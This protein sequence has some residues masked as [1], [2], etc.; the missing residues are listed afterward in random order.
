M[1]KNT[2]PAAL[3]EAVTDDHDCVR[4]LSILS[5]KIA[6]LAPDHADIPCQAQMLA[7]GLRQCAVHPGAVS[8][9][10]DRGFDGHTAVGIDRIPARPR[11]VWL[12]PRSGANVAARVPR[13]VIASPA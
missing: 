12:S 6:R 5:Q 11:N 2:H 13:F 9:L 3:L 7:D 8:V 10:P 1:S 4:V